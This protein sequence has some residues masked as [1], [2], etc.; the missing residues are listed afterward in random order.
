MSG[1]DMLYAKINVVMAS[2]YLDAVAARIPAKMGRSVFSGCAADMTLPCF[3]ALLLG[4]AEHII[5]K[6]RMAL[7]T[8]PPRYRLI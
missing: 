4:I 5:Y 3:V 7:S 8:W 2:Y 1:T 6:L